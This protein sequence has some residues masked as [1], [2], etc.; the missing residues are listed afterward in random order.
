MWEARRPGEAR[1]R[2]PCCSDLLGHSSSD[3]PHR[4]GL[5]RSGLL[6]PAA[7]GS[8]GRLQPFGS[9]H[10]PPPAAPALQREAK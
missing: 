3:E 2:L 7:F 1:L 10:F 4:R 9:Y 5:C 6:T 8:S